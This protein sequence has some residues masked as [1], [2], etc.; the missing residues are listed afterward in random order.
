MDYSGEQIF[1]GTVE[2][3]TISKH[4]EAE[5]RESRERLQVIVDN[6]YDAIFI[7]DIDGKIVNV[8]NKVLDLYNVSRE[9][10]FKLTIEDI[11]GKDNPMGLVADYWQKVV[12]Y[13]E[14]QTCLLKDTI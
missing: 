14:R 5:I 3:I 11:S 7:H 10:I 2:D 12:N 9:E 1:E 4:A 13:A 6:L 8:N